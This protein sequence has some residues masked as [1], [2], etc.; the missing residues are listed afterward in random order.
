MIRH[1]PGA[2]TSCK[3]RSPQLRAIFYSLSHQSSH[4][5]AVTFE[6][7][8]SSRVNHGRFP[9][10][11]LPDSR[12]SCEEAVKLPPVVYPLRVFRDMT[13]IVDMVDSYASCVARIR[14]APV[15]SVPSNVI[16]TNAPTLSL[17]ILASLGIR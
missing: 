16:S 2:T 6:I 1:S 10:L 3:D 15:F 13:G 11:N 4:Y 5:H 9:V 14:P 8:P 12:Q 17:A 7:Y